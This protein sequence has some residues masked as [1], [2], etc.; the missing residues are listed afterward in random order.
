MTVLQVD[1]CGFEQ[2]VRLDMADDIDGGYTRDA[3]EGERCNALTLLFERQDRCRVQPRIV[4]CCASRVGGCNQAKRNTVARGEKRRLR[5]HD[6]EKTAA[7]MTQTAENDAIRAHMTC[8]SAIVSALYH[9]QV[10][11]CCALQGT[12][13]KV[14]E[15]KMST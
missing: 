2:N 5:L 7:H 14:L 10:Q 4:N 6:G 12:G 11:G 8:P 15:G 1:G 13:R 3:V 9:D